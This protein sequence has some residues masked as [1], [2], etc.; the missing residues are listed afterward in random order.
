MIFL[1]LRETLHFFWQ[2]L[3]ELLWRLLP[4]FPLLLAGSY[5]FEV[6]SAANPEKA[7]TDVIALLLQMLAGVTAT[8]FT[9][10]YTLAVLHDESVALRDL[11]LA[12]LRVMPVLA[13]VQLLAGLAIL[14]GLL[15]ILPGIYL[16]GA[17]LP[18]YVLVVREGLL[19]LPALKASWQRFRAQAWMVSASLSLLMLGLVVVVS[20]LDS[21]GVLLDATRAPLPLRVAGGAGLDMIEM[22]FAQMV[23]ILLVRF[24][25]LEPRPPL[26]AE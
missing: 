21:L 25:E 7:M 20:G 15:L 22:L 3:T 16:M 12:T 13:A 8:A 4:V 26:P 1:R 6:V 19:P 17:L 9:I 23:A 2:H 24:Y 18:A 10:R 11:W 14:P 5:R